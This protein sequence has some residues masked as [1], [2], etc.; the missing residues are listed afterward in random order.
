MLNCQVL[1]SCSARWKNQGQATG[2]LLTYNPNNNL[3]PG[4]PHPFPLALL[5][6][7]LYPGNSCQ[8]PIGAVAERERERC[9]FS[10]HPPVVNLD[11]FTEQSQ[12]QERALL[13]LPPN[14]I[15]VLE[16]IKDAFGQAGKQK[17]FVFL[18][19][20]RK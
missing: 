2:F 4:I 16:E 7:L 18:L 15:A 3:K 5:Q 9:D 12:H 10:P 11:P 8:K 20:S 17:N 1:Q 6:G 19:L 13:T 14:I